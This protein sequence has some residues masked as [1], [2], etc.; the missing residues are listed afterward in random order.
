MTAPSDNKAVTRLHQ[1]TSVDVAP[2]ASAKVV[3][4]DVS[5]RRRGLREDEMTAFVR[6]HAA[7]AAREEKM[8]CAARASGG[9]EG[10]GG[11]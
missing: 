3:V 4:F 2:A 9:L 10:G 1:C 6:P 5:V 8:L 11:G 7:A